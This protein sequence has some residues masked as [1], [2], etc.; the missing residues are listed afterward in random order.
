MWSVFPWLHG[1]FALVWLS[2]QQLTC[3]PGMYSSTTQKTQQSKRIFQT[4]C[5]VLILPSPMA[6]KLF[7]DMLDLKTES[8][9]HAMNWRFAFRAVTYFLAETSFNCIFSVACKKGLSLQKVENCCLSICVTS[10]K[11]STAVLTSLRHSC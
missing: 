2:Q 10:G 3:M 9:N 5:G 8:S 4:E 11:R 7:T 1:G 6:I